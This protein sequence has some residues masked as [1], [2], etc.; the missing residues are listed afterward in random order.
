MREV[1]SSFSDWED[2]I[3]FRRCCSTFA[4]IG[5]SELR[6]RFACRIT[7]RFALYFWRTFHQYAPEEMPYIRYQLAPK[8]II[9]SPVDMSASVSTAF[10]FSVL[11]FDIL[12]LGL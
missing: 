7:K 9:S 6:N 1:C 8:W 10:I 2:V 3:N 11:S 5:A 4:E 12:F